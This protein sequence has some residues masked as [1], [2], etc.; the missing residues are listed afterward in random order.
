MGQD[1][2]SHFGNC[3]FVSS[4]Y[5]KGVFVQGIQTNK[6]TKRK[7]TNGPIH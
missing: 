3:L 7:Q 4:G 1:A 5:E 2:V 6:Q